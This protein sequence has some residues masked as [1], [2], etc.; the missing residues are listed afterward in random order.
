MNVSKVRRGQPEP[1]SFGDG[2]EARS[3]KSGGVGNAK[4]NLAS[5]PSLPRRTEAHDDRGAESERDLSAP[6]KRC[7][8][9]T[10]NRCD[11]G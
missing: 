3:A 4:L 6:E 7:V 1:L 10:E 2:G 11:S 8:V 5:T 9:R